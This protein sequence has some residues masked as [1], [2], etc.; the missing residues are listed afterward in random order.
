MIV[1]EAF[2]ME[3]LGF[4]VITDNI[5]GCHSLVYEFPCVCPLSSILAQELAPE[6]TL[7]SI[8]TPKCMQALIMLWM[9]IIYPR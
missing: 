5:T 2:N 3:V 1:K 6:G 8:Y 7:H 4:D 9:S